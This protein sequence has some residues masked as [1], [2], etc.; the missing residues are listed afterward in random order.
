MKGSISVADSL[1]TTPSVK[2]FL[3]NHKIE[4]VTD[5][6]LY[7]V[8]SSINNDTVLNFAC[9]ASTTRFSNDWKISIY[10][11]NKTLNGTPYIINSSDCA[12]GKDGDSGAYKITIPKTIS[13]VRYFVA[14]KSESQQSILMV[15]RVRDQLVSG[16][17]SLINQMRGH[18]MEFGIVMPVGRRHFQRTI[19]EVF[20]RHDLPN[21]VVEMMHN[22]LTRLSRLDEQLND[23][24][25]VPAYPRTDC[26]CERL[27]GN[28]NI[29]PIDRGSADK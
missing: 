11:N 28:V 19:Q 7:Y 16:R 9:D 25:H 4:L 10:N 15:H 8:D 2:N 3:K 17:T 26:L 23:L 21:L 13:S 12:S 24:A 29:G 20:A 5:V 6:Q 14:V 27:N 1:E 22:M 18:L